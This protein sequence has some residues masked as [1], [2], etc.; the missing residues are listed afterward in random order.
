MLRLI[1]SCLL[2]V[3]AFAAVYAQ[4]AND[5]C[6]NAIEI[7]LNQEVEFTTI[8]A[9]NVGPVVTGCAGFTPAEND[10]IPAD[11]WYTFTAPNDAV[12]SWSN[13]GT[14]LFDSRMAVYETADACMAG[15]ANLVN[16]NDDGAGCEENTSILV[17]NAVAGTTYTLRL[18]GFANEDIPVTSG[19]G[20]VQLTELD[21]PANDLCANAIEVFEGTNQMFTTVNAMTDGPDHEDSG[22]GAGC[23]G[24]NSLTVAQ[25]IWYTFTPPADGTYQWTTCGTIDYDSRM[26]VYAPGSSCPPA[27]GDLLFCN[28]DGAGVECPAEQFHSELFFDVDAGET[29]ILRLGGFNTESGTGTFNLINNSPPPP[30]A[31]DNCVDAQ[32]TFLMTREA[33]DNLDDLQEGNTIGASAETEGYLFPYC[34]GNQT[35]G[36]FADVWYSV[37]SLGNEEIEIRLFAAG[38]GQN[39]ATDFFIDVFSSCDERVDSSVVTGSCTF[40]TVDDLLGVTTV[41]GLPDENVTLLIR[42]TT[43]LTGAIPG[44][45]GFQLVADVISD[46]DDYIFAEKLE[47]FPN[48]AN[49]QATVRFDLPE[50][51]QLRATVYDLLGRAVVQRDLG[52]LPSGS[53]QFTINTSDL[54]PGVYSMLLTDGQAQQQLKFVIN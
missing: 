24:F 13:C 12:I 20:I 23:F 29:Y 36:E 37:E 28:D 3:T 5:D 19:M 25:D 34:L 7:S 35:G 9:T 26:A 4:P 49:E 17:F 30:P 47:L 27:P 18:G 11:I 10:S 22:T 42:V 41:S 44:A 33:A 46:V 14:A 38:Q 52:R 21:V 48:P 51:A 1:L 50:A 54:A 53:Q 40:I 15:N 6:A 39:P 16:C 2:A 43:R 8:D 31:N 32:P 45:F